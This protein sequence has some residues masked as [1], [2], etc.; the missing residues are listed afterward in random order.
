MAVKK[1]TGK[2]EKSLIEEFKE[3]GEEAFETLGKD[4]AKELIE[5]YSHEKGKRGRFTYEMGEIAI[6]NKAETSL[7]RA[8]RFNEEIKKFLFVNPHFK[9]WVCWNFRMFR[10]ENSKR[11]YYILK[12]CS[13]HF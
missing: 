9:V 5:D 3:A 1:L 6:Q 10:N 12:G 13:F 11:Y 2:I 8:L 7:K 4:K